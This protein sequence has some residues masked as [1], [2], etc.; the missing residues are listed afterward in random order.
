MATLKYW[1]AATQAWVPITTG[2]ADFVKKIGDLMTG[3]LIITEDD[4]DAAN[5][6]Q[7]LLQVIGKTDTS[8]LVASSGDI[9]TLSVLDLTIDQGSQPGYVWTATDDV[10]HGA[11]VP[12]TN[13]TPVAP[14]VV[15]SDDAPPL[16]SLGMQW[17]DTAS[18]DVEPFTVVTKTPA[19]SATGPVGAGWGYPTNWPTWI[20]E[21]P[22]N[23]ILRVRSSVLGRST[24]ANVVVAAHVAV[25]SSANCAV[26][27]VLAQQHEIGRWPVGVALTN[28][29]SLVAEKVFAITGIPDSGQ[30]QVELAW[31]LYQSAVTVGT[32]TFRLGSAIC[33]FTPYQD[34]RLTVIDLGAL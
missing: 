27:T 28:D 9:D 17:W 18:P 12:L 25:K 7:P 22:C 2:A 14:S 30:G 10:G 26:D 3:P 24:A 23:G 16:P 33:E 5:G 15:V 34:E 19:A 1:D 8:E 21:I 20:M 13:I 11:W 31:E 4:P 6:S 32:G 29:A